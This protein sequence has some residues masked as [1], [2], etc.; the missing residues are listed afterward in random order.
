MAVPS[1]SFVVGVGSGCGVVLKKFWRT[2]CKVAAAQV[3]LSWQGHARD[4]LQSADFIPTFSSYFLP[5]PIPSSSSNLTVVDSC[6][7]MQS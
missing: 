3:R 6:H 4:G 7:V 2:H 1:L 5:F